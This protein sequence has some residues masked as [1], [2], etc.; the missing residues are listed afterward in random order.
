MKNKILFLVMVLLIAIQLVPTS[1]CEQ[2]IGKPTAGVSLDE[3]K[4]RSFQFKYSAV[5]DEVPKDAMI[6]VWIP[7]AET[8]SQQQVKLIREVTP[9]NLRLD[10]DRKYGNQI[11]YFEYR[12]TNERSIEFELVYDVVRHEAGIDVEAVKLTDDQ[13]R[14]FLSANS[15]VPTEGRP[16]ELIKETDVPAEPMAAGQMLYNF[17]ER[18]MEYDKSQPGYGNGDAVW[19]CDSKTGNCTDFHSLFISLARSRSIPARFEIGFP[20]PPDK[21]TGTIG[22]YHCWAWFHVDGIGWSPV[23]ISEA[24]K[25]PALKDYYFGRLSA[26]RVSFSTG[27]DIDLIPKSDGG[28]M[29]YLIYPYVE[30]DG[31]QWPKEKIRMKF[32]FRDKQLSLSSTN[33][34]NEKTPIYWRI[35]ACVFRNLLDHCNSE[36]C[37]RGDNRPSN[38]RLN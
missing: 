26:D 11:G 15:L 36:I 9:S 31:E 3:T 8:N 19:A 17:V 28:P 1:G 22:G 37:Q 32:S 33:I 2:V 18:H 13:K 25:H 24:D 23:D 12:Q 7:I 27:R 35:N 14:I 16:Q 6:R 10:R 30:V 4:S 38:C 21:T 29:N 34:G 5:I 20:I